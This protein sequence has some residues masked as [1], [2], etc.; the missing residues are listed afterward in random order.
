M[1]HAWKEL[2]FYKKKYLLIELLIIVMMFMVVF[3]SGLA[4]GLGRAVSAAIENNPAQTYILNE[5]AEQVI[6]SSVL[7]TKDQ[8]D[9]N[10]LN[11][12]DSTTLNIQRSSLTRQG[13]EKK[14][15]I[16]Y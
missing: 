13:H 8:T 12:K 9:L 14:I 3:L 10:S 16:S 11:L 1:S 2:T 6:T 5:G 7:T 4:N 15:D